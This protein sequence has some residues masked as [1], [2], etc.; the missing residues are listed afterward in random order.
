MTA[1]TPPIV[2]APPPAQALLASMATFRRTSVAEYEHLT[3][4]GVLTTEDR[5]ELID[6]K[7]KPLFPRIA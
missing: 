7:V 2:P 1:V 5:V 3:R 4:I 6:G